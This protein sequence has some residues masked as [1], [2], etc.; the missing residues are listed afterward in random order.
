[1]VGAIRIANEMTITVEKH[2]IGQFTVEIYLQADGYGFSVYDGG[3]RIAWT[4]DAVARPTTY[5]ALNLAWKWL[6]ARGM[7]FDL[8]GLP[9]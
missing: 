6:A 5:Q 7:I 1:M 4:T 2:Q 8:S 9:M 3:L